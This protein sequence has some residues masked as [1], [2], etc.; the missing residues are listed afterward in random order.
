MKKILFS[1]VLLGLLSCQKEENPV[2]TM[3]PYGKNTLIGYTG[4]YDYMNPDSNLNVGITA[5]VMNGNQVISSGITDS[6][7]KFEIPDLDVGTYD[8]VITREGWAQYKTKSVFCGPGPSPTIVYFE[9]K[10]PYGD[11]I[12]PLVRSVNSD[13]ISVEM[14]SI[15][16]S[17]VYFCMT[18]NPSELDNLDKLN[19][20]M[21]DRGDRNEVTVSPNN[22]KKVISSNKIVFGVNW[23]NGQWTGVHK[24]DFVLSSYFDHVM[25]GNILLSGGFLEVK[26]AHKILKDVT[27]VFP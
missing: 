21:V 11:F 6:L 8:I 23:Y 2:P 27:V 14:D 12:N 16:N 15:K 19:P 17:I 1:L 9:N 18:I 24:F 10:N 5:K 25:F 3:N 20:Y 26:N 13:I 7:G 4:A 22:I